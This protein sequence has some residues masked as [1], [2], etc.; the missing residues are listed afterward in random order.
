MESLFL[1]LLFASH[2]LLDYKNL[3]RNFSFCSTIMAEIC[4]FAKDS[5]CKMEPSSQV[6]N[7]PQADQQNK[8]STEVPVAA[9]SSISSNDG[10]KVSREDIELVQNLIERCLQLYMNKAEVVRTLLN[11]ARIE[12]GFTSLVWQK[13]EEENTD[14]FKAYYIRLKLK[15]QIVMFN[16]LLERQYNLMKYPMQQKV[17]LAPIQ[18]GIHHMPVNNLPIGYP[19]IQQTPMPAPGQPHLDS[20]GCGLS[21]CHVVNGV[22]ASGNFH[23]IRMNSGNDTVMDNST[24]DVHP[25]IPPGSAASSI[26]DMA[27]G[28]DGGAGNPRDSLTSL[29]QLPWI[30][31]LSDLTAD[32]ANMEDLGPLGNYTGSPFLPS[33]S[34]ILLDSSEHDDLVD[35]F[36]VD[37]IPGP[38]SQSEE[39]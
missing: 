34:D 3:P 29:A 35:E 32:L 23:P 28:P 31:S 20:M 12:P 21:S 37:S 36:F 24:A 16:R 30:F 2:L 26:S 14:F 10:R 1:S 6:S 9:E 11:R 22:P 39:E 13:L 25:V 5:Q 7:E 18:N 38:C 27:L 33:E 17:P 8:P 4:G 15:K 19:V